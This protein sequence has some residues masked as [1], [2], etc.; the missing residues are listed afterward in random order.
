MKAGTVSIRS[1]LG[2]PSFLAPMPPRVAHIQCVENFAGQ[3]LNRYDGGAARQVRARGRAQAQ[4][5]KLL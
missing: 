2:D 3:V 4:T 1:G 5:A